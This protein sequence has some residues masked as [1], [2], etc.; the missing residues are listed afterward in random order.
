MRSAIEHAQDPIPPPAS[1]TNPA[2]PAF[3][4]SPQVTPGF[5]CPDC[6]LIFDGVRR[7]APP[8]E[9]AA[10]LGG[11]LA[12]VDDTGGHRKVS[13]AMAQT[14]TQSLT[15]GPSRCGASRRWSQGDDPP[16]RG[17]R[18]LGIEI[19]RVPGAR[20]ARRHRR[21]HVMNGAKSLPEIFTKRVAQTSDP[22]VVVHGISVDRSSREIV[23]RDPASFNLPG[24]VYDRGVG[25][26]RWLRTA[27]AAACV[28]GS[29]CDIDCG[30]A[31]IG[32]MASRRSSKVTLSDP[33]AGKQFA[34]NACSESRFG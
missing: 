29:A 23:V 9:N 8:A 10:G 28:P 27:R 6:N 17:L 11:E 5:V 16:A 12:L 21:F 15:F 24:I 31:E 19:R 25:R 22:L 34:V 14:A 18:Q 4:F 32:A 3:R 1:S 13:G 2:V 30:V 33:G 7:S 26:L 20:P